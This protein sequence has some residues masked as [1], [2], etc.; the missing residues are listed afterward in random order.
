MHERYSDGDKVRINKPTLR[1]HG[2]VGV[3]GGRVG[4]VGGVLGGTKCPASANH[5]KMEK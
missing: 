3:G 4:E 2:A 5:R 1:E